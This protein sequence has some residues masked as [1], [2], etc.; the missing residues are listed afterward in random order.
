MQVTLFVNKRR[1]VLLLFCWTVFAK[2]FVSNLN[3]GIYLFDNQFAK[4]PK[5]VSHSVTCSDQHSH[6]RDHHHNRG[7]GGAGNG[8]EANLV[9]YDC[10]CGQM[11][12]ITDTPVHMMPLRSKDAS[13]V[14]DRK[15]FTFKLYVVPEFKP[16]DLVY[17][18]Y[19]NKDQL[20]ERQYLRRCVQCSLPIAYQHT[21]QP[22]SDILFLLHRSLVE[23]KVIKD[24]KNKDEGKKVFITKKDMGKFSSVTVSTVDEEEDEI[25][26]REVADSYAA[27]ARIIERQLER[28]RVLNGNAK[29]DGDSSVVAGDIVDGSASV[30]MGATG[31]HTAKRAKGTLIDPK[32]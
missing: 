20:V 8:T 12:L 25:E 24:K 4:M 17:R 11:C 22:E 29:A 3:F 1:N 30:S 31:G 9:I 18:G 23:R 13:R 16:E 2:L 28:K 27:N 6:R 10:L 7:G 5:V 19:K 21:V 26:E 14:L 15:R 32:F